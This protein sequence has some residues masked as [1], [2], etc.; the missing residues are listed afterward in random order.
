MAMKSVFSTMQIVMARS[1][2]GSITIRLTISL[3]FS[4]FGLHSQIRKVLANLYQHGGH[5]RCDSSSSV[6]TEGWARE[7]AVYPLQIRI[8]NKNN[9]DNAN[10]NNNQQIGRVRRREW[11]AKAGDK[12]E[13]EDRK[14]K[15]QC[16]PPPECWC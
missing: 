6:V 4:H 11:G 3:I 10:N 8:T 13:S 16:Y 7:R 5:E 1:T 12:Y 2:K 9:T 14:R 15:D